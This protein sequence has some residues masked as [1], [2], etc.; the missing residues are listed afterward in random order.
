[1]A[2]VTKYMPVTRNDMD[3]IIYQTEVLQTLIALITKGN[4][5]SGAACAM[6]LRVNGYDS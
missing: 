5:R 1:M 3:M 4:Y 6:S 2:R